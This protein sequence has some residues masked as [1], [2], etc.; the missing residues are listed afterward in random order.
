MLALTSPLFGGDGE[1]VEVVDTSSYV[2]TDPA[3]M[4]FYPPN[5]TMLLVDSEVDETNLFQGANLWELD[6]A[7]NV[8]RSFD[9]TPFSNEPTGVTYNP[10]TGTIF[11]TDDDQWEMYE[12]ELVGSSLNLLATFDLAVAGVIDAEGI[13]AHPTTGNLWIV[14]GNFGT[15]NQFTPQGQLV[16]S[17]TLP[18]AI[19]DPESIVYNPVGGTFFVGSG[20]TAEITEITPAGAILGV[21]DLG[22]IFNGYGFF[23]FKGMMIAPSSDGSDHPANVSF[24]VA[25]YGHDQVDDGRLFELTREQAPIITPVL[26]QQVEI[27]TQ[28]TVPIAAAD[29]DGDLVTLSGVG[30]PAFASFVDL[31]GGVAELTLVPTAPDEGM[32]VITIEAIGFGCDVL[33]TS[34]TVD[35]E[36]IDGLL[37]GTSYCG[38][39]PNSSG[40]TASILARGSDVVA[41]NNVEL[42][43]TGLSLN[44]F[45]YFLASPVQGLVM[46]P[47]GSDGNLCLSGGPQ[48]GR[49]ADEVRNSGAV[50]AFSLEIDLTA[51][52]IATNPFSVAL[53]PG[54][55]WNFQAWYRDGATSNFTDGVQIDFL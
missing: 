9:T 10:V 40:Q 50:G 44:Q 54:D 16:S 26:A 39:V 41:D 36:V 18:A 8:L 19:V 11:I 28:L 4:S 38:S 42:E 2:A 20:P 21:I 29:P 23:L 3:G 31:G 25:D 55:T 37:I 13:A 1:V 45:G 47:G 53:Q 35:V 12:V 52:P 49:F 51:I 33:P 24:Y 32:H 48:L 17:I 7:G 30:L 43:A 27:G 22:G 6:L 46:N 14:V 5:G 15:L 34:A